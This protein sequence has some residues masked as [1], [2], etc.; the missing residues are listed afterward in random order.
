MF[1][2]G[3][4]LFVINSPQNYEIYFVCAKNLN[5]RIFFLILLCFF[6]LTNEKTDDNQRHTDPLADRQMFAE[7]EEHPEGSKRWAD[8]VKRIRLR[9]AYLTQR[10]AEQY[11]RNHARKHRQVCHASEGD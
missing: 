11:K 2:I 4:I 3:I 10:K 9:H 8:I 7:K 1:S 5:N 6:F